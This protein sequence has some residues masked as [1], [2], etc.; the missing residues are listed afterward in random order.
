MYK[1][2]GAETFVIVPKWR[3]ISSNLY[4]LQICVLNLDSKLILYRLN[5]DNHDFKVI[6]M[7]SN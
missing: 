6:M 7:G 3:L 5:T 2:D 4:Q 1:E